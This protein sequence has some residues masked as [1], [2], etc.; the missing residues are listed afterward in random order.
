MSR[1]D[2]MTES[3]WQAFAIVQYET[4]EDPEFRESLD[5]ALNSLLSE[6]H[7]EEEVSKFLATFN[8]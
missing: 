3:Q 7:T 6:P 4:T 8:Q 5:H 2:W 1:P